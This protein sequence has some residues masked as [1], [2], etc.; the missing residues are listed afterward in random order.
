MTRGFRM[1]RIAV[2]LLLFLPLAAPNTFAGDN[3]P[4]QTP[5]AQAPPETKPQP[6]QDPGTRKLSRRERKDLD[7]KSTRLNSSHQIISYAVFCLKK[8]KLLITR[9]T[10]PQAPV[11]P[12]SRPTAGH[13][14]PH[15]PGTLP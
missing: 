2:A 11:S 5:Q 15:C 12:T 3:N 10:S 13:P 8:K 4:T 6:P 14:T 1:T 7:R 9:S